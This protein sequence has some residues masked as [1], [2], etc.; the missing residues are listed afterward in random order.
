MTFECLF[1]PITINGLQI[2][3]RIVMPAMGL[4]HDGLYL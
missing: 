4:L 2:P 1:E 3:N